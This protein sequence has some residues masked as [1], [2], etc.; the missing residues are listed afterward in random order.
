VALSREAA[1][2]LAAAQWLALTI[3]SP[4]FQLR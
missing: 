3:A 1:A 4:E 2:P